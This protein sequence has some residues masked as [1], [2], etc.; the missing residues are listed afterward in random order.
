MWIWSN[1]YFDAGDGYVGMGYSKPVAGAKPG[2][3]ALAVGIHTVIASEAKQ[4]SIQGKTLTRIIFF[5]CGP[6]STRGQLPLSGSRL[7]PR[8]SG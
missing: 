6:G 3:T 4:S 5:S 8:I 7:Y 1:D 2:A